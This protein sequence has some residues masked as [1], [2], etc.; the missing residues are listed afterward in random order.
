VSAFRDGVLAG[1]T[2]FVAGA[3]GG[4]NLGIA[5]AL[6]RAGAAVTLASRSAERIAAAAGTI[7]QAGGRALGIAAD[8]RE[9]EVL[10]AAYAKA[11]EA[12]GP[13]DIV[14]S[15]AAGNFHANAAEL[16]PKGFKTVVDIDLLGTFNVFRLAFDHLRKPGASLI[17]ITAPGARRPGLHQVH[18]NAAKAG[19]NM[20]VQCLAMEWGPAGIR[21]N[22][23]SP[24]PIAGTEGMARLASTPEREQ[25]IRTRL[26]LRRY[27][28]V[29]D[30][31]E[32]ALYLASDAGRYVTGAILDCDGGMV[33]GDASGDALP[34]AR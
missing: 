27:G 14:I 5:Q 12:F 2:A 23:I 4:I 34:A 15:G 30:V 6:A 8:V 19:V 9:P 16:S 1:R 21:V 3:S 18:A 20:V 22:A 13:V 17:A 11:V 7:T 10:Q 32:A 26:A 31:A 25:A 28:E 24:G 29:G 33:L